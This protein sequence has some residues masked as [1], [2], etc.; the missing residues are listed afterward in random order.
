MAFKYVE[1]P[2]EVKGKIAWDSEKSL[3]GLN[4][5]L[6]WI[7]VSLTKLFH[8]HRVYELKRKKLQSLASGKPSLKKALVKY[9][10]RERNRAKDFAHKLTTMLA[11]AFKGYVHG[12]EKLDKK[13][14]YG[15]SRT[16]IGK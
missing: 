4:P 8:I 13:G 12:F 7:R 9:S 3:D 10:R 11:R 5:K 6:G 2:K 14:M 15:K 1:E 16:H